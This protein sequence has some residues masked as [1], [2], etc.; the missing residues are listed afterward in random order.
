MS[1]FLSRAALKRDASFEALAPLLIPQEEGQRTGAAHRLVWSLFAD[2]EDR[3][4][5]FLWHEEA[6]GIFLILSDRPPDN[7]RGLFEVDQK[8][9]APRLGPGDRLAFHL[10]ANPVV[11]KGEPNEKGRRPRHDLV[12]AAI[13]AVPTGRRAGLRAEALGWS[14]AEDAGGA[15]PVPVA[16]LRRQ[17]DKAGFTVEAAVVL[18]YRQLRLTRDMVPSG[19]AR[20]LRFSTVDLEGALVVTDPDRFLPAIRQGFGKAKAF[21]CGLM[22]V[23][24]A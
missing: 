11:T 15:E 12:M 22:L 4:R 23:R 17:G 3:K 2:G 6:P 20:D 18:G 24:R 1:L 5:D 21:G 10:R 9:F 13:A 7:A 14:A 8:P 19:K 16:W